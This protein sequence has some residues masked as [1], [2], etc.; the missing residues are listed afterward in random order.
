MGSPAPLRVQFSIRAQADLRRRRH[1]CRFGRAGEQR[2]MALAQ[3]RRFERVLSAPPLVAFQPIVRTVRFCADGAMT[4]SITKWLRASLLKDSRLNVRMVACSHSFLTKSHGSRSSSSR[5]ARS[6]P[7]PFLAGRASAANRKATANLA[8]VR[9]RSAVGGCRALFM[10][11]ART[12]ILVTTTE[13][14][15]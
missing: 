7:P 5:T 11:T 6:R 1:S 15:E 3:F 13:R 2:R 10:P 9:N 4:G 8:G 14:E 12:L